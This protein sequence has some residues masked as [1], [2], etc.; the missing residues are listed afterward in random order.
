MEDETEGIVFPNGDRYF[1][2][3]LKNNEFIPHGLGIC[4]YADGRRY[5]GE[6][7][8]G[9]PN[10]KGTIHLSNGEGHGG[11]WVDGELMEKTTKISINGDC[12][13]GEFKDDFYDGEGMLTKA[14]GKIYK[15]KFSKGKFVSGTF[16]L[17]NGKEYPIVDSQNQV[18]IL[19][20]FTSKLSREQLASYVWSKD[21]SAGKDSEERQK[22][23]IK[24]KFLDPDIYASEEENVTHF[25]TKY[26]DE[27]V[28][29]LAELNPG[30]GLRRFVKVLYPKSKSPRDYEYDFAMLFDEW[31][32]FSG[33]D[34]LNHL[35]D[36]KYSKMVNGDEY[37][38]ITGKKYLPS[39]YGRS[40]SRISSTER[41]GTPG[42]GVKV[43]LKPQI[44]N[45]GNLIKE[46]ERKY[47]KNDE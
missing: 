1:G 26:S 46:S 13:I 9:V 12:Y 38:K 40:T 44:F 32:D 6:W 35:E 27:E 18:P 45:W 43:P 7:M 20:T 21:G 30:F 22:E 17:P 37:L 25:T 23:W 29:E 4:Y 19:E 41:K 2:E 11:E 5:E 39:G 24:D 14:K 33:I 28:I 31:K 42:S 34:L 47:K 16:I 3:S 10:G 8:D 15:G 36:K